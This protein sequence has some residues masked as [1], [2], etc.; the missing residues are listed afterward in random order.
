MHNTYDRSILAYRHQTVPCEFT[1]A[2]SAP[3]PAEPKPKNHFGFVTLV[4]I[5]DW[6]T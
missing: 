1:R 5:K 2:S 3:Q 4:S 6:M